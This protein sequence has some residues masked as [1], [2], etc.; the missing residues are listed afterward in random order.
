MRPQAEIAMLAR[1]RR[2][3]IE[4]FIWLLTTASVFGSAII[5]VWIVR[6]CA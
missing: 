6:G 1:R 2:N 4:A 3:A 5:F